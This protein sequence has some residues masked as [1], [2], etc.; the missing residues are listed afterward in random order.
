MLPLELESILLGSPL[1]AD[2]VVYGVPNSITG[3]S[4]CVDVEPRG[5]MTRAEVRKHVV[6]FLTGKVDA[7]KI[8]SKVSVVE[9][10]AVSERFKKR[11][12]MP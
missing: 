11:R 1:I 7:F 9:S 8:P 12:I 5:Q 10:V 4:V 2:C 6:A 3:Q